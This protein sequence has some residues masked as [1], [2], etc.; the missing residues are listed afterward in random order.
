[1]ETSAREII[2]PIIVSGKDRVNGGG[3][4]CGWGSGLSSWKALNMHRNSKYDW[5]K[6]INE[7]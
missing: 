2:L 5:G 4:H 7:A 3:V 1:M 6:P